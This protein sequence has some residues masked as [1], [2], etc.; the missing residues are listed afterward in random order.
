MQP[1]GPVDLGT[2]LSAGQGV[3]PPEGEA[4]IWTPC[5]CWFPGEGV[6]GVH[7]PDFRPSLVLAPQFCEHPLP[8]SPS[9]ELSQSCK[10]AAYIQK[11][12]TD[13]RR[14]TGGRLR[15]HLIQPFYPTAEQIDGRNGQQPE[16]SL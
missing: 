5:W 15:E 14:V 7:R 4:R 3:G 13:V 10:S 9:A 11:N 16:C 12:L 1:W 6:S 2:L 8:P